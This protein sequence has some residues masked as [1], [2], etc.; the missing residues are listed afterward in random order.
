M[1][2]QMDKNGDYRLVHGPKLRTIKADNIKI[3][4]TGHGSKGLKTIGRRAAN[5]IVDHVV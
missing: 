3:L 1:Q 5:D 4:F 2:Q